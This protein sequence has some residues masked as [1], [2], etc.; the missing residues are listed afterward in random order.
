LTSMIIPNSVYSI[1]Y[2]A[3]MDCAGI[4]E[5]NIADSETEL[6]IDTYA[7]KSVTPSTAYLGRNVSSAIFKTNTKLSS[8][9]IG[10]NVTSII[11]YAFNGCTSLT[12]VTIPNSA[13]SIGSYAFADCSDCA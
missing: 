1:G 10:D 2:G 8:I 7:F 11:S 5:L 3:F 9:T 4:T 12:S 13:T 6:S